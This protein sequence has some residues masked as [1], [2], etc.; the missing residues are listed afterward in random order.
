MNQNGTNRILK[1]EKHIRFIFS[2]SIKRSKGSVFN[3]RFVC[4]NCNILYIW[5][6]FLWKYAYTL[7]FYIHSFLFRVKINNKHLWEEAIF[8]LFVKQHKIKNTKDVHL[9]QN[10]ETCV[11][12]FWLLSL[13]SLYFLKFL[14]LK[15]SICFFFNR[16]INE[17]LRLPFFWKRIHSFIKT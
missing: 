7:P 14:F 8:V 10:E 17:K 6:N 2:I 16:N 13:F 9:R 11:G 12:T 4:I 3:K 15:F 1:K 5:N